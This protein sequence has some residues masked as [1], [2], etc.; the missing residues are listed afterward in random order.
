[1]GTK[2]GKIKPIEKAYGNEVN[3]ID[4]Q[5]QKNGYNRFP[6]TFE[7]LL[8]YK[9]K[10]GRYRTGLDINAPYLLRLSEED[11]EAK[12]KE[13]TLVKNRLEAELGVPGILDSNSIFYNFG[14]SKEQ[15]TA[16]FGTDLQVSP[17]KLGDREE[18]FDTSDISKEI[19]WYW[20]SV[21]PRMAPS[22]D[23]YKSG[24]VSSDV[25]YYIVDDEAETKESYS[26]KKEIN[27]AIVAFEDL[28]P[29]KK[30][31][32]GR[33]MGLPITEFTTEEAVYNLMDTELK[34]T[35]FKSGK[36]K[37]MSPIRLFNELII[38]TDDRLRVKDIVTQALIHSVYRIAQGGKI[39]E[40]GITIAESESDLVE[41]LLKDDKQMDL[42]ILEKKLN[43]KKIE[44]V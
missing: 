43:I 9:E 2:I 24:K 32:I 39:T 16:R 5:L 38:M 41:K 22:L 40:G 12:I 21:H 14:A 17:V 18:F 42:I 37:G 35:E 20:V 1:M 33:L 28:T 34:N 23:A 11:R 26:K 44:K 31:Q 8:P 7:M 27:K 4:Q 15:L 10:S 19:A 30:K 29:S 6:G 36:N 13:I 3:T 25:K